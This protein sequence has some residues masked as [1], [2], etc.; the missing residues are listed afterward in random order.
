MTISAVDIV[1]ACKERGVTLAT[2]ESLTGGL[3]AT[4]IVE[5]PGS[6]EVFRGGVVTYATDTKASVLGLDEKLLK[7]VVSEPVA[8]AMAERASALF[9]ADIAVSTTGVAGPEPLD[10]QPPG[11]AWVAVYAR[12][13]AGRGA[14]TQT[15]LLDV[16]GDRNEVRSAVLVAA[17]SLVADVLVQG[18]ERPRKTAS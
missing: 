1:S 9:D 4:G 15:R 17:W 16:P 18:G 2:A 8:K 3:L 11:T 14:R 12:A 5:V 10:G 6:S 13:R 7:H